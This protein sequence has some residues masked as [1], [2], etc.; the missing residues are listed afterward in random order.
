M[1]VMS[2]ALAAVD[3]DDMPHDFRL[4]MR[5]L[6]AGVSIVT[7]GEGRGRAGLTATSVNSLSI[8]P[9]CLLVCIGRASGT[10]AALQKNRS[11]GVSVLDAGQ[12]AI[13]ERF[14]GNGGQH[15]AARFNGF[16]WTT[17]VT[18]APLA[19][20]ALSAFDCTLETLVEWHSHAIVVGRVR[21]V[22]TNEGAAP[23]TYWR[24]GYG[25]FDPQAG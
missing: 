1:G 8:D 4:A 11:F 19:E 21:S 7:T 3:L 22:H 25:S 13:A 9:P 23:L 6:A 16:D 24:G 12:Q 20:G 5:N 18:G 14:A 17:G 15:G 10:L 2:T